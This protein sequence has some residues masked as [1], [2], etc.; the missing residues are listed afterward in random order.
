[1]L[2]YMNIIFMARFELSF[3]DKIYFNFRDNMYFVVAIHWF[4]TVIYRTESIV[5][6]ENGKCC[7]S[8][9]EPFQQDLQ[10]LTFI[11]SL[12]IFIWYPDFWSFGS[13]LLT[14]VAWNYP[15]KCSCF[16]LLSTTQGLL[17]PSVACL[18][19]IIENQYNAH[20]GKWWFLLIWFLSSL[21]HTLYNA[22]L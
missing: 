7:W 18:M 8:S 15:P 3:R 14:D 17:E 20:S 13:R 9:Y 16:M 11:W 4:I 2:V 19:W 21:I 22:N 12:S 1:M 6:F 5:H 10:M